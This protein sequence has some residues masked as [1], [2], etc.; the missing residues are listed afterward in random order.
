MPRTHSDSATRPP[1][2][3]RPLAGVRERCSRRRRRRPDAGRQGAA[4]A[5]AA[6]ASASRSRTRAVDRHVERRA[7]VVDEAL[8]R[9]GRPRGRALRS[10]T[11][12]GSVSTSGGVCQCSRSNGS[13][14]RKKIENWPPSGPSHR[15]SSPPNALMCGRRARGGDEL[16]VDPAVAGADGAADG[17]GHDAAL[18]GGHDRDRAP[19]RVLEQDHLDVASA[20]TRRRR[21]RCARPP[22]RWQGGRRGGRDERGGFGGG[23]ASW[24]RSWRHPPSAGQLGF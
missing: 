9:G 20:G 19:S 5:P 13:P 16:L 7:G 22:S 11:G 1:A 15:R 6:A 12:Q 3:T 4:E 8:P 18:P 24:S 17:R 10:A 21:R 14:L 2:S 23:S